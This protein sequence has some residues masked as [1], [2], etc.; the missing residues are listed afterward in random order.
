MWKEKTI[1]FYFLIFSMTFTDFFGEESV[2]SLK[3]GMELSYPP[4][5]MINPEGK[6][7]GV[8]VEMAYAL[9]K[10]LNKTIEIDNIPFVGLIPALKTNKINLIISSLSITPERSGS[11]D[12]STPYASIGLC[13][14]I[15]KAST[16]NTIEEANQ[17]GKTVVVKAGTSGEI[18]ARQNLHHSTII[19]LDKESSCVLEV[20][21]GKADAFIYDQLSIYT[22]WKKNLSTTRVNLTPFKKEYWAV[23]IK[24]GNITLLNEVNSFIKQFKEE[25]GFQKLGE[26]FL[27]EQVNAFKEM[28]IP[29]IF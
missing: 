18:Y 23:G 3:V 27:P 14:L 16:I 5:E 15:G 12:F 13:L 10:S 22:H 2:T 21:Q 1:L 29:F 7:A 4:F 17:K 26:K 20:V 6:P 11:I 19:I 28:G 9:G 25:K 8:S 24:K